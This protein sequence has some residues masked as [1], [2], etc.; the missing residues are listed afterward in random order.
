MEI[1]AEV[2]SV[3]AL[4]ADPTMA[5]VK[6]SIAKDGAFSHFKEIDVKTASWEDSVR[7]YMLE[8]RTAEEALEAITV[9]TVITL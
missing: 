4:A 1:T 8:Y 7:V 5:T 2:V 9:G 6:L 3:T